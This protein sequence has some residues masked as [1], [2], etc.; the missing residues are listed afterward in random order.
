M[1]QGNVVASHTGDVE[2]GCYSGRGC[3]CREMRREGGR[4]RGREGGREREREGGREIIKD[5]KVCITTC[6]SPI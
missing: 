6:V 5:F 1:K 3:T 2:Y 4:E